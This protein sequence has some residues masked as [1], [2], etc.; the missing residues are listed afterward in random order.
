MSTLYTKF[1]HT[2]LALLLISCSLTL[3]GWTSPISTLPNNEPGSNPPKVLMLA[4]EICNNAIDDDGDGLIDCADSDCQ[5]LITYAI[6][7]CQSSTASIDLTVNGP[8]MPFGYRW[9]DILAQAKWSFNNNTSDDSGNN[10]HATQLS[11]TATYDANDRVEGS[12]SFVFNG[13]TFIRF[14]VDGG[15]LETAFSATSR[16]FWIKPTSLTGT[17]VLFEQGSST[18][19]LAARLNGNLLSAAYRVANTQFTTGNLTFPADGAWHHVAVV[20]NNGTLTIYLDGVASTPATSANTTIPADGNND[21]VGAR[22]GSDAFGHSSNFFYTGKMDEMRY[23]TAALSLQTI[24]DFSRHDGDRLSLPA[25]TYAVTV[26]SAVG[27][28]ATRSINMAVPCVEICNNGAD[29]DGDGQIDNADSDCAFVTKKLYLSGENRSVLSPTKDSY[30]QS[31]RSYEN[32]GGSSSIIISSISNGVIQFDLSSIPAGATIASAT[33]SLERTGG[34]ID[35]SGNTMEVLALTQSWVEGNQSTTAQACVSGVNWDSQDCSAGLNWSTPGGTTNGTVYGSTPIT[36]GT[37]NVIITSLVQAWYNGSLTNNGLLL[38]V[39]AGNTKVHGFSSRTGSAPPSLTILYTSPNILDRVDPIAT[40]DATTAETDRLA[41]GS[42]NTSVTFTQSPALCSPLQLS[43]SAPITVSTYITPISTSTTTLTKSIEAASDDA[44]E[45]GLDGAA[46]G[47][48][49]I[50][51]SDLEIT[52]DKTKGHQIVGVRFTG[53]DIPSGAIITNAFLTF[54][55]VSADSPNDNTSAT[56]LTIKAHAADNPPTFPNTASYISNSPTTVAAVSWSPGAWTAGTAYN[57][58]NLS[59]IVQEIANRPGW[60]SGNS[61]AFFISGTGSRSAASFEGN[62]SNAPKLTVEYTLPGGSFPANPN[63]TASLRHG[64]TTIANLTNPTYNSGTGL[65]TWTGSL[66]SPVT[67]PAN[68]AISLTVTTA[69]STPFTI[70]YDSQTKPSSVGFPV[71]S[72]ATITSYAVYSAPFPGGSIITES[73]PGTTVYPRAVVTSPFGPSDISSVSIT[74]TPSGSTVNAGL[75]ASSGCTRTYEY[76]WVTPATGGMYSIPATVREGAENTVTAVQN[77]SFNICNACPPDAVDD[78]ALANGMS[79]ISINVLANDADPNN[80]IN[81]ATLTVITQPTCGAVTKSGNQLVFTPNASFNGTDQFTYQVC[82][83]TSPT[84]LCDIAT[85]RIISTV[86]KQLYLSDPGQVLDRIDPVA[87]ADATTAVSPILGGS[88]GSGVVTVDATS[89]GAIA[90]GA[91]MTISHTTGTGSNRLMLVGVSRGNGGVS[92]ITY[93]GQALSLV[94]SRTISDVNVLL[95]AMINPPS[96][97]ANV[98]VNFSPSATIG[99]NVGVTTFSDVDVSAPFGVVTSASGATNSFSLTFPSATGELAYTVTCSKG[100]SVTPGAGVTELYD[101]QSGVMNGAAGIMAGAASVNMAWTSTVGDNW[102]IIGIS[103]KPASSGGFYLDQFGSSRVYNS[104]HGTIDWSSS[105]WIEIAEPTGSGPIDGPVQVSPNTLYATAPNSLRI[106]GTQPSNPSPGFGVYRAVNLG[107]ATSAVLSYEYRRGEFSGGTPTSGTLALDISSDGGITWTTLRTH[108]FNAVDAKVPAA[109]FF[110]SVDISAFASTNTRLRFLTHGPVNDIVFFIDNIK[111]DVSKNTNNTTFTQSP[112]L[113]SPLTIKAGQPITVT[114]FVS[115]VT[116]TMPANPN[117]TALLKYGN[118]NIINLTN[119]SYNSGTGLLTWTGT[120]ASDVTVPAGQAISLVVTSIQSGVSFRIEF[121]SQ[122]KPSKI[123]LPVSTFIDVISNAFYD[124]P[125]P[126]G[127]I[128]TNAAGGTNVY[129]RAV[130]TDP[131]GF[132]DITNLSLKITPPGTT[133]SSNT[134]ATAGCT[135]TYE[136]LYTT[137]FTGGTYNVIATAKEGFENTVTDAMSTNIDVCSPSVTT[138]VFALGATSSRCIGAGS[139]T[140]SATASSHTGI[141]YSLDAASLSAGN[142]ISSVTGVVNYTAA[143][144]GTTI[145]TATATGCGGPKSATHT[146]TTRASVGTP[147]FALGANSSR[148]QGS[149]TATYAAT[150]ANATGITYSL[151]GPSLAAG[152]SIN[153]GTGAVTFV[154]SWTNN[155]TI[156]ASAAGCS[157]PKTA[158]HVI[159][160]TPAVTAPVFTLGATSTRCQGAGTVTYAATAS[161]TTGITYSL[162]AASLAAGNT[163]N[164]TTGAVTYVSSWSGTTIITASAAG[165]LGPNNSTHTVTITPN[166]TITFALGS[167]TSRAFGAG[168]VTYSATAN[169]SGTITYS[170]DA[171]SLAAGLTINSSTGMVTYNSSWVGNAIITASVTGCAGTQTATHTAQTSNVFKQ[172][173]L[174]DPNQSL[175]RVDPVATADATTASTLPISTTPAGV[176]VDAVST[177]FSSNPVSTTFTVSHTTGAGLNRLMLVGISQKNRLVTSVTYG[178]TPL[179]LVGEELANGSAKVHIYSLLN[180]PSGTANVVVNLSANPDKGIVVGVATYTGVNQVEPFGVFASATGNSNAS[181]VTLASAPGELVFDIIS[182]RNA[183][184]SANAGQNVVY[185]IDSGGEMTGGVSTKP[186]AASVTMGWTNSPN[187]QQWAAAAVGLRPAPA[188]TNTIF[189]QNPVLCTPLTIKS[190]QTITVTNFV[191]ILGGT[192]PASPNITALLQYGSTNIINMTNP[193]YSSGTGLLTWTGVLASDIT[194]PAGQAI[195]LRITTA[196]AGVTFRIDYDSQTKP[197]RVN[198]PVTTFISIPTYAVYDAPN[199]GGN[200]ITSTSAGT[201]VY[202]RAVVSDP[203]GF[204]DI[205]ALNITITPPGTTVAGTAVATAGCTKTYQYTWN[206]AG[207]GGTYSL[208]ATAKEGFENTVSV[209]KAL[210][211]DI[212]SPA[213][214]T[215]VFTLGASSTRC[216]GA[217]TTTYSATSANSTGISYSL[218]A[219]SIAAGNTIN[220]ATGAVTFVAGWHSPSTITATA[221]GCGGPKTA[222]HTVT[223][224]PTVGTPVFAMGAASTRCQGGNSVTYTASATNNSGITYSLDAASISGGNTINASTGAV[225]FAAGWNGTTTVTASAAGCNGPRTATHTVTIIPSVGTPVFALGASS[226]RCGALVQTYTA[227]ASNSTSISYSLD[228][229]SLAAG[230]TINNATGS[231]TFLS[232]WTGTSTI[233]ATATGCV[234]PTTATHTVTISA[235]CP[236]VALDDAANGT[237]GSPLNINVLANDYDINN[238]INPSSLSILTHPSNGSAVISNNTF[239]YLPNGTFQGVDQFTYQICDLTS[240]TPLCASATVVVTIDPTSVDVCSEA[241]KRQV[242]YLPFPEQ[243][244]FTALVASS[245]ASMLPMPSNTIR[246]VISI[247]IPYP[248]MTLV[249][250]HWEDGYEADPDKPTQTTTQVWGDGNPYNGIAPGYPNDVFP[251]GAAVVIDNTMPANPRVPA[252][253]FYDGKDKIISSGQISMTQVLGE[254]TYLPVQTIK[255][256]VTPVGDFG[257][258]FTIPVGQNYPSRDFQYTALFVR[259]SQNN[260]TIN[261]DKDNNGTFETNVVLNEG[262]NYLVNGGVLT[263]ATV[264]ANKPVGV[265]WH[266]AG[267]DNFSVRNAPIFPATWYSNIYYTPVPTTQSPDTCV[268]MLYNSLNRAININWFFGTSSSGTINLP[269]KTVRR[270]QLNLSTTNAYKFVN[271]TGESFTAIEIIDSYTPGGG[272]NNGTTYDWSFNLISEQRLTSFASV[273]WAPGGLD[274]VAPPGPDVNGNPVWVTPSS[275]TTIY[276]KWDGD[277]LNGGSTSPCGFKFDN[278]YSLNALEYRALRDAT[279]NDQGGL[280]V[281]T[282]DG[283]KIAAVYGADPKGSGTGIGVAYWDVGTTIQPFCGKKLI[284]ANDDRAYTLTGDP[285]TIP[286]LKNDAGFLAVINPASLSTVGYLQPKNGTVSVNSNGTILYVP[287]GMFVGRDTFEY[288]VCSTLGNPPNIVCDKATVVVEINSCPTPSRQNLI[289]GNVF[290]DKNKDGQNNDGGT[291]FSPAKVYLFTDANCNTVPEANELTDSIIVDNSGTYQFL[292]YPEKTIAD[293]FDGPGGSNTCSSGSDGSASWA[294]NWT[295]AG[296]ASVGFCVSPAQSETNTDVEIR[297]DGS[298]GNALRL[299]DLNK[300]A[301]RM[302]NIGGATYAFLSFSYRRASS[303]LSSGEDIYVQVS[304]DGSAFTTIFTISGNGQQDNAY[305]NVFNQDISAYASST[306]FIRFLT[307]ANVD[308]GDFVFFDNILIKYL[309]YPQ[310]Y[311]ARIDLTTIPAFSYVTTVGQYAFTAANAG[312]C[313]GPYDFG[314]ARSSLAISGTVFNDLNGLSDGVVNG[315]AFGNPA[316]STLYAYLV[317]GTG[318]VLH[319]ATVNAS[320]GSYLFPNA[321]VNTTYTLMVTTQNVALYTQAPASSTL[322]AGWVSAGETYGNNNNAGLG[323]EP[324]VPNSAITIT[325]AASPVTG[326][327]IGIQRVDGGPDRFAC[328][329]GAATMAAVTTPGTWSALVGNPG[330]ST[331]TQPNSPTSTITN[332]SAPGTYYYLWTNNL[333]SDLVVVTVAP[334]LVISAQPTGFIQCIGGNQAVSVSGTGGIALLTY[335]WQSSTDN[336]TFTNI[337]GATSTSYVPPSTTAG[338]TY[339]RVIITPNSN[340]CGTVISASVPGVV[341]GG[342]AITAQ[343]ANITQCPNGTQSLSVTASGGAPPLIYQWQSSPDSLTFT[344]ISGATASTYIPPAAVP[345]KIFYRVLVSSAGS[346]CGSATT[347]AVASVTVSTPPTVDLGPDIAKCAGQSVTLTPVASGGLAPYT[348]NWNNGLGSGPSKTISLSSTTTFVVTVTDSR[349]CTSTDAIVVTIDTCPE[350]CNNGLDDDGDGLTDCEDPDCGAPA[351][352]NATST[353]PTN[354]P[355][356]NNGQITITA[357]G[358]DLEYSINGGSSFQASNVFNGLSAGTYTVTVRNS[359]TGC[360]L[361]YTGNPL[362]ITNPVCTEICDNGVDDDGDGLADCA[363]ADCRPVAYAGSDINI[364]TGASTTIS[365]AA[366]SGTGPFTFAWSHGLGTGQSKTVSPAVTT[367]YVVT[368][369]AAFGCTATDDVKV[370][371][372][373]CPEICADGVDN[374]FDGLIDCADPDCQAVGQPQLANDVYQTCPGTVFTEQP[375]FNDN[376]LQN[377]VYSIYSNAAKGNV[378]INY[379]G[380]FTYTPHSNPTCGTDNFQ[381]QVCNLNSGCCDKATVTLNIGDA[382]PPVLQNMPADITISCG[383][384]VPV[385]PNV[386]GVDACPGIYVNFNEVNNQGNPGACQ[387]Y[388]I[389]RTW[390][391]TDLCGNSVSSTQKISVK[392]LSPPEI[393]RMYTLSNNKRLVAGVFKETKTSWSLVKFPIPFNVTPLVFATVTTANGSEPVV[394]RIKNVTLEGFDLRIQEEELGDNVH[395]IERVSWMAIE[396]GATTGAS[397]LEA[398]SI[399]S[400]SSTPYTLNYVSAYPAPP[401]LITCAQT[402]NEAD[403]FTVRFNTQTATSAQLFLDEEQ[404]KDAEKVHASERLAALSLVAGNLNDKDNN[405]VAVAGQTSL[406]HTWKTVALPRKFTKPVVLFGGQPIGND[407]ATIRVRNVTANSFEVRIEE[408]NYL[409][410][411]VPARTVSY[412]VVEGSVPAYVQNPCITSVTPMTPGVNIFAS[413]NCDNQVSLSYTQSSSTSPQGLLLTNS[414]IAADDCGNTFTDI[415]VDTCKLA[416]VKLKARLSGAMI[417]NGSG[418]TLMRDNLRVKNFLPGTSP[419]MVQAGPNQNPVPSTETV[420]SSML[421]VTGNDAI[422]DWV[423]VQLRDAAL[424]SKV[425]AS[426]SA[427]IQRDGDV[428]L[429][430]GSDQVVFPG[431]GEGNYY[432]ILTHRNH[433][434]LMTN[435]VRYLSL[436]NTPLVDFKLTQESVYGTNAGQM[437]GGVRMLWSGD[438]NGDKRTIY[439]GPSNDVFKLFSEVLVDAANNQALANFISPGY[440]NADLNM[441]GNTV[442]QGPGN[443][444]SLLLLHT[445]LSH[446]T[447]TSLL[448]NFIAMAGL[449]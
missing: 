117:V 423:L 113:C 415:R 199:P 244:A 301:T 176:V 108:S 150:A 217:A 122:T 245:Q 369:T 71:S 44:E 38:K 428:V 135:K 242:Y 411:I 1:F 329:S 96:G 47:N 227:T 137:P 365:A 172:L 203:F 209:I 402:F 237:G 174:S 392:D 69:E 325:T 215:P 287:N 48:M 353:N 141:T 332:F 222:T 95:Y 445:I 266:A 289:T 414:W 257:L 231:A 382:I 235:A 260:T 273:A 192:M 50:G 91:S 400:V 179:T 55:G 59:T 324:G 446:P 87:T 338:T 205:T 202:P 6:T 248:G 381:Y 410:K 370:T 169:N 251:A 330:T 306:T 85:V 51:S 81:P 372:T 345:G 190:G 130:V 93:A 303:S 304:T 57:S 401:V 104:S 412:I 134:V 281:Y 97:T 383:D 352:T 120:L 61:M 144:N 397:L 23:Y 340:G 299:D 276:V 145:I 181:S 334:D 422:V 317:S 175:D 20:F 267:V 285:V 378:T 336:V 187:A 388:T 326:V 218:D 98:I 305:V 427:L 112:T 216:Q 350:V 238:N 232:T 371:P 167:T 148:C 103:I 80:N 157:G 241:I 364:C 186:G 94:G 36:T 84:P 349:G 433:L 346:G 442:Y 296:D 436:V 233:T 46:P 385:A 308:E 348:F 275:N 155:T 110:E 24:Q 201:I 111:I 125:F 357:T 166:G 335:Q 21:A 22:N 309:T 31:A 302:V 252:N 394:V 152:N 158:T 229:G 178:G 62:A 197:S 212:C 269:A 265:E 116:G 417:G 263:G 127:N 282:C 53:L 45:E 396:P 375:I 226:S 300:S 88:S 19:G 198:L 42:G 294:S 191:T 435:S 26:S 5:P 431:V 403:P 118:T 63:V 337:P 310:C 107:P 356:L 115:V 83:L 262:Q 72:S 161:N 261:I 425:I 389:T 441:D 373:I 278:S 128:I 151:D 131:F 358:S 9:S 438:L 359:I 129:N 418:V 443:D 286:V 165:C 121:D 106:G 409:D 259:A 90:S 297:A 79:A 368:I 56:N 32:Q 363:D 313:L 74:I 361:N 316:G 214:G 208:P 119:P 182:Y 321:D 228:A 100:A 380:V 255:T 3:S 86:V 323:N 224:T 432:V 331:I 236:P 319:K 413:D 318:E 29:D 288:G 307:N 377:P 65:L 230:N 272:G 314:V 220:T 354:C 149:N 105:S 270:F 339:Y 66:N 37:N 34:T 280:A 99:A 223:I 404:S 180:P 210:N 126:G 439:Q 395:A 101:R 8:N 264:S 136:Y 102:A 58:P 153:S 290:L 293:N 420:S 139:T 164:A 360:V 449:P 213:I 14:G 207:L 76:A 327:N 189:T 163:I 424:P 146:V 77:L 10:Q 7:N 240:P 315:S 298:F 374:D 75:V 246:T 362:V 196:Q 379:Q 279:D 444:R 256:N 268:V 347:S 311:I 225:A 16:S 183:S 219:V 28:S 109:P 416:A 64:A 292:V 2:A 35:P 271:P 204:D 140:Y 60:S 342:P 430:D 344:N 132:N 123:N 160:T 124:A 39:A 448:A 188:I 73:V 391:A 247:K 408:W 52:K 253:I 168:T 399:A 249:W 11:G 78:V 277:L 421:A 30:L 295:D 206:T 185:N 143:W 12:N 67:I 200:I 89:S 258:S 250:D 82:D 384:P 393:F 406:T 312:T 234:G 407:P 193:T 54:G 114:N 398:T 184:C 434:G 138:P 343:P 142:T 367:T 351:I 147:V 284:F 40:A 4:A 426:R 447:N 355:I 386:F 387:D 27:C 341:V 171:T 49:Y 243:D 419:Y 170:L 405:F 92:S 291:G 320:N 254:P 177:G 43:V 133:V 376:N 366:T 33:L 390:T 154:P 41:A 13:A 156:T 70:Q 194:V 68:A 195:S 15:F 173:Y 25:G 239:V 437:S 429:P 159:T 283:A 274:L 211:F 221:A 18:N 440:N 322:P 17:Q 162:N 333:V 328:V